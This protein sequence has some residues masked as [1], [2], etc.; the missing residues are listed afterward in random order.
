M[1]DAELYQ[2]AERLFEQGPGVLVLQGAP[3]IGKFRLASTLADRLLKTCGRSGLRL[4]LRMTSWGDDAPRYD[5]LE[6]LR[7][8]DAEL[9]RPWEMTNHQLREVYRELTRYQPTVLLLDEVT[10][11]S[12]VRDF[13]LPGGP[14]SL[15]IAS[16]EEPLS[17]ADL[18]GSGLDPDR[19][20]QVLVHGPDRA[21]SRQIFLESGG[22]VPTTPQEQEGVEELIA[23]CEDRPLAL[24]L[25][26]G[27]YGQRRDW[28][29]RD[30]VARMRRRPDEDIARK[31]L[32]WVYEHLQPDERRLINLLSLSTRSSVE[33]LSGATVASLRGRERHRHIETAALGEEGLQALTARG[34]LESVGDQR[35]RLSPSVQRFTHEQL[36]ARERFDPS[37]RN[38]A[39][40]FRL[41][42]AAMPALPTI[43]ME[44][45]SIAE[46][47]DRPPDKKNL[48]LFTRL[49]AADLCDHLVQQRESLVLTML[50]YVVGQFADDVRRVLELA[51]HGALGVLDRK[52]GH[53]DEARDRLIWVRDQYAAR[54][55]EQLEVRT[56]RQIGVAC[57]HAGELRTAV[58]YLRRAADLVSAD[59]EDNRHERPWILRVLGT[60]YIDMGRLEESREIL[61][62]TIR[63]H[64]A[65]DNPLGAAWARTFLANCLLQLGEVREAERQLDV[66]QQVFEARTPELSFARAWAGLTR[67]RQ[68]WRDPETRKLALERMRHSRDLSMQLR[69]P[70]GTAYA[71]LELGRCK[72][73][74]GQ[75]VAARTSLGTAR[76][77]FFRMGNRLGIA[78]ASYELALLPGGQESPKPLLTS[79]ATEF[80]L[81]GEQ[82]AL[83]LTKR[84]LER[85]ARGERPDAADT[86]EGGE[87]LPETACLVTVDRLPDPDP[88]GPCA[89]LRVSVYPELAVQKAL[90]SSMYPLC[91]VLAVAPDATVV[92]GARSLDPRQDAW[93]L[94]A[95]FDVRREGPGLQEVRFVVLNEAAGTLLQDVEVKL[96]MK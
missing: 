48:E 27:I 72:R 92:P 80:E 91:R 58:H 76:R 87:L 45:G 94:Q 24:K 10:R 47:L 21:G 83:A 73:Q 25:A 26:A 13:L 55:C 75:L 15:V 66:A 8:L 6:L 40:A 34:L 46:I 85:L 4:E 16:S 28:T 90:E 77:E 51:V 5:L 95:T 78:W 65:H 29:A 12:G 49:T 54:N 35:Y 39:E 62:D 44:K 9:D 71:E 63:L 50:L 1:S 14:R 69:E 88:V 79:A 60:A 20:H 43:P 81:C 57:Y 59:T 7:E 70:L 84:Q 11:W 33:P 30:V 68:L 74:L 42:V 36:A 67:G 23:L 32:R 41:F 52:S 93:P 82:L 53:L 18:R 3:G 56:L 86:R 61:L 19:V 17:D 89:Q 2:H 31:L 22:R 96:D 64:E 38:L 37:D